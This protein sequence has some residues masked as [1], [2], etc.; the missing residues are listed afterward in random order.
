MRI[1]R[2]S[3]EV[4]FAIILLVVF[5]IPSVFICL[6][7]FLQTKQIPIFVQKRG[8]TLN[9]YWFNIFKFRTFKNCYDNKKNKNQI[10]VKRDIHPFGRL[11]RKTGLDEI[12][13]LINIIKGE[14]N[15]IGPRPLNL[16]DLLEIKNNFPKIYLER[17]K[18]N[19]KPGL[20]GWWQINKPN[21]IG[22]K[23]LIE[24]DKYYF[25]NKSILLDIKILYRTFIL[26]V[27]GGNRDGILIEPIYKLNL[28][29]LNP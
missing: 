27:S 24:A 21:K 19:L 7:I 3:I 29:Y 25:N 5:L 16:K 17:E 15:F 2:R 12:P 18:L 13:Q 1:T 4:I 11:L 10:S 6:I 26:A 23:H 28:S 14:M 9:N 20:T 8:L 22:I